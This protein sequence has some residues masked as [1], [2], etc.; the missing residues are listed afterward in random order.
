MNL[1]ILKKP[2][3]MI[4]IGKTLIVLSLACFIYSGVLYAIIDH[5]DGKS[6]MS[7]LTSSM[8]NIG[9]EKVYMIIFKDG[10]QSTYVKV[11]EGQKVEEQKNDSVDFA[12]WYKD[13]ELYDFNSE[14]NSNFT[15]VARHKGDILYTVTFNTNGGNFISG[16]KVVAGGK[17]KKP[18]TPTKTGYK[19]VKWELDGKTYD[20]NTPI[21]ENIT[22]KA[23]W[24]AKEEVKISFDVDGG[25]Q[26]NTITSYKGDKVG[27]LPTPEKEGYIFDGWYEGEVKYTEN[28]VL[29]EDTKL[30]AKW[31]LKEEVKVS[32]DTDGAGAI[33]DKKLYKGDLVGSLPTLSKDGYDFLGWYDGN[34]KYN[35][36]TE[37]L[38]DVVLKA[39]WKLIE[40]EVEEPKEEEPKEDKEYV[41]TFDTDG[42]NSI[43]SIKVKENE[44]I[45]TLQKPVKDG[46]TFV[47]WLLDDKEI[48]ED[49]VV[50]KDITLKAKWEE[51]ITPV[52]SLI[53]SAKKLINDSY[54][55][56]KAGEIKITHDTCT[57]ELANKTDLEKIT[58]DESDKNIKLTFNITCDNDTSTKEVTGIIK[59]S[60]Y[61]FTTNINDETGEKVITINESVNGSLYTTDG[62]L[63]GSLENGQIKI[64]G[65]INNKY[66]VKLANDDNTSY[67]IIKQ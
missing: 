8:N 60:P 21:T 52:E 37:V 28:A 36:K 67:V 5:G 65:E 33:D 10:D 53:D 6:G 1:E 45:G 26:I 54:E 47:S 56:T 48:D 61:T 62:N 57:I 29:Y 3:N 46:F 27:T 49:Y 25:K 50:T 34:I 38:K 55:I 63:I 12:G 14:V 16:V 30:K 59:K 18:T 66:I 13:N 15:L 23:I 43:Q 24:E 31:I 44:K 22:L 2:E 7:R 40:K 64:D 41:V 35:E 9:N 19:F 11:K 58:R 17:V 20:F 51:V 4:R 39:K 42:G 32:F